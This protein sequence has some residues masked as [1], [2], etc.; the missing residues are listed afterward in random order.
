MA[1]L[2]AESGAEVLLT[3]VLG[4]PADEALQTKVRNKNHHSYLL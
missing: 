3:R 4:T 1:L 2:A